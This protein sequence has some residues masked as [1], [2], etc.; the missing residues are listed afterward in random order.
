LVAVVAKR[1]KKSTI[2]LAFLVDIAMC[3]TQNFKDKIKT[4]L[5][6]KEIH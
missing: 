6:L 1:N 3:N 5:L 2:K 4:S